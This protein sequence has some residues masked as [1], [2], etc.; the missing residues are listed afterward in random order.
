MQVVCLVC[1]CLLSCLVSVPA[2]LFSNPPSVN[3]TLQAA[4]N[5]EKAAEYEKQTETFMEQ[6][7]K[8]VEEKE[9]DMEDADFDDE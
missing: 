6:T 5:A 4:R 9:Q 7:A 8:I 1:V 2:F 3:V